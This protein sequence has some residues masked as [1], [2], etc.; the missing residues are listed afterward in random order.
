MVSP[1]PESTPSSNS[2]WSDEGR[3]PAN[4]SL[5]VVAE[6]E[7]LAAL[8]AQAP[9]GLGTFTHLSP[10]EM[11]AFEHAVHAICREAHRLEL[12]AEELLIAIKK[13]WAQLAAV[14]MSQLAE[15]DGDV[16]R[17]IVSSSIEIFFESRDGERCRAP[18]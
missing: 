5:V 8:A 16:L 7:L 12:R 9:P 4:Q 15:R 17:D 13:A 3:A 1:R 14:R 10:A 6:R 2:D 18:R 11:V